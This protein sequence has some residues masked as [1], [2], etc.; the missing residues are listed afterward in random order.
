[1][2]ENEGVG[3]A[4]NSILAV[5]AAL[6]PLAER[7]PIESE[8][9]GG[10]LCMRQCCTALVGDH[11]RTGT[12]HKHVALKPTPTAQRGRDVGD[13]CCTSAILRGRG[14]V[15]RLRGIRIQVL[16]SPRHAHSW[17]AIYTWQARQAFYFI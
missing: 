9:G 2:I 7:N 17:R 15:G 3:E 14:A 11:L 16:E 1:M 8:A 12:I 4:P 6:H 13:V 10:N 5:A